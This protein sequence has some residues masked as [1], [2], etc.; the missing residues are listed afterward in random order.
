[1]PKCLACGHLDQPMANAQCGRSEHDISNDNERMIFE[2]RLSDAG[3]V[4]YLWLLEKY[5]AP[6]SVILQHVF[7]SCIWQSCARLSRLCS[8]GVTVDD[9]QYTTSP[10]LDGISALVR[11]L[12]YGLT[13][14]TIDG[15]WRTGGVTGDACFHFTPVQGTRNRT[16]TC[17][18]ATLADARNS[19]ILTPGF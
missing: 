7:R 13:R 3:H 5:I 9:P 8:P 6:R 16:S 11:F 10:S 12:R 1:V 18:L 2:S 17:T 19:S 4:A 15:I 14:D